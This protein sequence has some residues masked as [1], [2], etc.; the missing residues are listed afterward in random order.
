MKEPR[1]WPEVTVIV[2]FVVDKYGVVTEPRVIDAFSPEPYADSFISLFSEEVTRTI[3]KWKFEAPKES[4]M[5][6]QKFVFKST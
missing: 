1:I 3:L 2:E 6:K 5:A 4:C